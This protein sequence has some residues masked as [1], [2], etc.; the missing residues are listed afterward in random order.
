[1]SHAD[2]IRVSGPLG[3]R[4]PE[5]STGRPVATSTEALVALAI[6]AAIVVA[7]SLVFVGVEHAQFDADQAV[8]GLM[9]KHIAQLRAFPFYAYASDYVLVVEAWLAA[10]FLAM[11]GTS[12]AALRLPL[13]LLNL[14]AG[15]M[16]VLIL[17]RELRL[18]PLVALIPA[19]FFVAAPPVLAAELLTAIGGNVEPFVYVLLLWLTRARPIAFGLI[20]LVGFMNREF[21]AY[22]VSALL[23]VEA[24]QG[25]LWHVDNRRLKTVALLAFAMGWLCAGQLRAHADAMGPGT[26]GMSNTQASN[27]SVAVGFLCPSIDPAR[28][29]ANLA[30]LVTTQLGTLLG[31]TPFRLRDVNIRSPTRQGVGG[32]WPFFCVVIAAA[33]CRLGWLAWKARRAR[34]PSPAT[35]PATGW[36]ALYLALI[37]LQS[38]LVWAM[39]RC[40]P[41]SP[42]TLRYG[43]LSI[44][45]PTGIVALYLAHEHRTGWRRLMMLF[46]LCWTAISGR[47]HADLL[48]HYVSDSR[49]DEYRLLSDELEDRG[50]RY[51]RADY[52]TAYMIDFLTDE[53]VIATATDYV[54]VLEYEVLVGRHEDEAVFLS[55]R[56]CPGGEPIRHRYICR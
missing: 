38:G 44:L 25:R 7:R 15:G 46:V 18:R 40:G 39:T 33:V 6:V 51:V 42:I 24:L 26:S 47:A 9:A 31:A 20:F 34:A 28:V 43:L 36:F 3:E 2:D 27:V 16:L 29:A 48:A 13:V 10:P 17:S 37:G 45:L 19:L 23:V 30:S 55:R 4:V 8:T 50:I 1:M 56:R 22:A 41:L 12:V 5:G 21:T 14:L 35:G 49:P 32:L 54:R 53:R 52:W 11:F